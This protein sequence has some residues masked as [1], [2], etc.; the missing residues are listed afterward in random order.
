V[1]AWLVWART[2]ANRDAWR[3]PDVIAAVA[4]PLVALAVMLPR[5]L[6]IVARIDA[7]HFNPDEVQRGGG[8]LAA[9]FAGNRPVDLMNLALM[10]SP[11]ALALPVVIVT[12]GPVG[13]RADFVLLMALALPLLAVVPFIHPGQ[14]YLRDWDDFAASGVAL[15]LLAAWWI[16]ET[17]RDRPRYAWLGVSV[18]LCAAVPSA[19]WLVHQTDTMNGLARV[20]SFLSQP[21]ERTLTER[22][23]TWDFLALRYKDLAQWDAAAAAFG[24]VAQLQPSPRVLRM[25]AQS[26]LMAGDVARSRA[27]YDTLTRRAPDN[28]TAWYESGKLAFQSGDLD[29]A[30]NAAAQ[31]IRI[32]PDNLDAH[33][34]SRYL[35]SLKVSRGR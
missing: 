23:R 30:R 15:A 24:H 28:F 32:E 26:E 8:A 29:G 25:W 11:L 6:A 20:E 22:T 19:Q 14:G 31:M 3:R 4:L 18:A 16:A 17:L 13:R 9:A 33:R 12:G 10:L 21:P 27:I 7:M 34:L 1:A 2:H 5:M 35:D